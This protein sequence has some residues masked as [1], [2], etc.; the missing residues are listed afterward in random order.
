M[1]G[2][3]SNI[4]EGRDKNRFFSCKLSTFLRHRATKLSNIL[5]VLM[6]LRRISFVVRWTGRGA[7]DSMLFKLLSWIVS[8]GDFFIPRSKNFFS[9]FHD[10]S[11]N[12]MLSWLFLRVP[13]SL[14]AYFPD[15]LVH[16]QIV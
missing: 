5:Y 3:V 10:L 15:T 14:P 1:R 8:S 16:L 13:S 11:F 12:N 7:G 4:L 2:R 9:P 6:W